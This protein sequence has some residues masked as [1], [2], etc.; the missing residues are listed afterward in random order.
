M[1]TTT[2]KVPKG[3]Q[4]LDFL[5]EDKT[6]TR[7][8]IRPTKVLVRDD[9][10]KLIK[11]AKSGMVEKRIENRIITE[12]QKRTHS[13]DI[14]S[15]ENEAI[16]IVNVKLKA[17][18]ITEVDKEKY[19]IAV[20]EECRKLIK[21]KVSNRFEFT[22]KGILEMSKTSSNNIYHLADVLQNLQ[23]KET[24]KFE[25][26]YVSDDFSEIRK[27]DQTASFLP[28]LGEDY[29]LTNKDL[30]EKIIFTVN[31]DLLPYMIAPNKKSYGSKGYIV[32]YNDIIDE[33]EFTHSLSM[34]KIVMDIEKIWQNAK[35][36][37]KEIQARFGTKYGVKKKKTYNKIYLNSI[38]QI[39]ENKFQDKEKDIFT[40]KQ[41]NDQKIAFYTK[42]KFYEILSDEKGEY[43]VKD[44]IEKDRFGDP[45]YEEDENSNY[46]YEEDYYSTYR[47]FKRDVIDKA[48]AEINKK[49]P[50]IIKLIEHRER[51][52]KATPIEFLQFQVTR[53]KNN[54]FNN[55]MKYRSL[56][57]YAATRINFHKLKTTKTAITNLDEYAK[58]LDENF[59][60]DE[61]QKPILE[62]QTLSDLA[63][64]V[65][66]NYEAI[67]AIKD[68]LLLNIIELSH[69]TFSEEYL[70]VFDTSTPRNQFKMHNRLGDDAIECLEFI[71]KHY[72][73]EI[74]K[75][76]NKTMSP[77]IFNF[78]PFE[79]FSEVKG[80]P[81]TIS[82][83]SYEE[84]REEIEISIKNGQKSAF[85]KFKNKEVKNQFYTL[86]FGA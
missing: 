23:S 67:M 71:N 45:I 3:Q 83:K 79:F 17:L 1:E 68:I 6:L 69:L 39:S 49:S 10:G 8:E 66:E 21:S 7:A 73:K 27:R 40:L 72:M 76:Q 43:F 48:I 53:K 78:L 29:S 65:E 75:D 37:Y 54:V 11:V 16:E 74:E 82:Q 58:K 60:N 24:R 28:T 12:I 50:F 25:E 41:E 18:K 81:I 52:L 2:K 9:F 26:L 63:D 70:V 51:G 57:Y 19:S 13:I 22:K 85:K 47:F 31:E 61:F 5:I 64:K 42:M 62:I 56:G 4:K 46:I 30:N 32:I 55:I 36:S 34:Y 80:R 38:T 15:I 33:F 44:K 14:P 84:M 59:D 20:A 35:F 77:P 86:Y